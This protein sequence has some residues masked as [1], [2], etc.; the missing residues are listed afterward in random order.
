[1]TIAVG[2]SLKLGFD[3][4]TTGA[5]SGADDKLTKEAINSQEKVSSKVSRS[6]VSVPIVRILREEKGHHS[7]YRFIIKEVGI[8]RYEIL[9]GT[10]SKF[11]LI[12]QKACITSYSLLNPL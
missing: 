2:N 1:M 6:S 4:T 11:S 3:S 7:K 5:F 12:L 10:F 9:F 8:L